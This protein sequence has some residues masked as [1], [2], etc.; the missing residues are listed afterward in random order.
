MSLPICFFLTVLLIGA[1]LLYLKLARHLGL[2]DRPNERSAH[3]NLSTIRGGGFVFYLAVVC[4][5]WISKLSLP[6]VYLGLTFITLISFWDD[7][8]SVPKW[9]RLAIHML[10]VGLLT[11][12]E[13]AFL[14][15]WWLFAGVFFIGVGIVNA[16]NFMDGIN[17]MTA[18]YS[19]VTV[20]TLWYWQVQQSG[21]GENDVLFPCVFVALLV[22][23]YFNARRRAICFAG[24]VGS[25]S[26]GFIILYGLLASINRSHTYLPILFISVYGIDTL[27]TIIYR[28]YLRQNI[29]RAHQ[30]HLFQL[31]VHQLGWPHLRVSL[32][33]ALVQLGING[34]V[35]L[36]MNW[37]PISQF[38]LVGLIWGSLL[39][40][41]VTTRKRIGIV[42]KKESV[43]ENRLY[44]IDLK[45]LENT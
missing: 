26:M 8:S 13:K 10:A 39:I 2:F 21:P 22:F 32:L 14:D 42:T 12:Q 37:L 38:V 5:I 43:L 44:Y 28:L 3:L 4:A 19:L 20:G 36:A 45:N 24:D 30:M 16:Y 18:F 23:S 9:Y 35:I 1:E 34:L 33:Y 41:Y 7:I 29:F 25:I 27:L 15:Q 6:Y 17:G 31:L 11:F 40:A